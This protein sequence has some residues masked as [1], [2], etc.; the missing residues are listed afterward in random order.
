MKTK[1]LIF[2]LF[3]LILIGALAYVWLSPQGL[4]EAPALSVRSLDGNE[5]DLMSLRGRPVLVTFWATSCTGCVKEIP[6][7]IELHQEFAPQGMQLLAIAMSYDPPNHVVAMREARK[8][9]YTVV[10]DID[11]NAARAFGD[12]RLT[13]TS[14]LIAPDG[15]IVR[16]KVGELDMNEVRAQ[17]RAMLKG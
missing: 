12:V 3:A 16:E 17:L 4:K 5:V 1:D 13:P 9:P 15:R 11:G 8:L 6:H 14:F 2:G 10:L 7:L